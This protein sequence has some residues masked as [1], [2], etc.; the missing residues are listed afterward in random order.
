MCNGEEDTKDHAK[1]TY[2]DVGDPEERVL[3]AH[4]GSG[5]NED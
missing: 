4:D 5:R 3:S 1:T 2:D